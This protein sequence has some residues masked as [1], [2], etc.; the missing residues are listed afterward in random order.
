MYTLVQSLL[1]NIYFLALY[2][3]ALLGLLVVLN[4][5]YE[6][7][8]SPALILKALTLSILRGEDSNSL[9]KRFGKWAGNGIVISWFLELWNN[10][11]VSVVTGS[12]DGIGKHY[13]LELAKRGFNIV[14]VA[15]N[16][17]K[18]EQTSEE[19][20]EYF[21]YIT[22]SYNLDIQV[23]SRNFILVCVSIKYFMNNKYS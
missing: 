13:A 10:L 19:I 23:L 12:T 5:A 21:I 1:I 22:V 6:N 20:C 3:L 9:V 14:L 4:Y 17:C 2:A 15:R 18:L 8:R 16:L 7:L 11:C